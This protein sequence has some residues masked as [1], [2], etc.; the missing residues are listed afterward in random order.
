MT[1]RKLDLHTHYYP[2]IY[3]DKI[4]ELPSEFSFAK[5][6]SAQTIIT[7]RGARFVGVR[8]PRNDVA[9]RIPDLARVGIDVAV[10]SLSSPNVFFAAAQPE[11]ASGRII[12]D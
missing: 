5:S 10:V 1:T 11:P 8:P 2:P 9:Q 7:Y 6:T 12:Q 4:R 3:S